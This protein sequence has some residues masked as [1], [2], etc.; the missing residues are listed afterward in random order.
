MP[1]LQSLKELTEGQRQM[2]IDLE[3]DRIHERELVDQR[4]ESRRQ[5]E[6]RKRVFERRTK[7][8]DEARKY[9]R[10]NAEVVTGDDGSQHV[11]RQ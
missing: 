4:I 7:L 9:R 10:L 6:S 5:E 1:L 11:L 8:L 2:R 3:Q